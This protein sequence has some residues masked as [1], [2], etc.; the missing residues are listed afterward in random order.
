MIRAKTTRLDCCINEATGCRWLERMV[1]GKQLDFKSSLI[2]PTCQNFSHVI[3]NIFYPVHTADFP[4]I[5]IHLPAQS[6]FHV[7]GPEDL[8]RTPK[9]FSAFGV[10]TNKKLFGVLKIFVSWHAKHEVMYIVN[11]K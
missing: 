8:Q 3:A 10:Q 2:K 5:N 6:A 9:F 11:V 4:N 7:L 1:L